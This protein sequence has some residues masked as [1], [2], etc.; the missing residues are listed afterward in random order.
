MKNIIEREK[1][2]VDKKREEIKQVYQDSKDW[3]VVYDV[4]IYSD[5]DSS[6]EAFIDFVE[7][8][9]QTKVKD[10]KH[11]QKLIGETPETIEE[12]ERV[13]VGSK[14]SK[15]SRALE[16]ALRAGAKY[17]DLQKIKPQDYGLPKTW[18]G[19]LASDQ[20]TAIL[21]AIF[22]AYSLY[23]SVYLIRYPSLRAIAEEIE[24]PYSVLM[25]A[26]NLNKR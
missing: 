23:E 3:G 2:Y 24:A 5:G 10:A 26:Y 16:G 7:E 11:L 25:D 4:A 13:I 17:S 15:Y 19:T 6:T 14:Y 18:S 1:G 12:L 8:T 21:W 22:G 20:Y 9:Y